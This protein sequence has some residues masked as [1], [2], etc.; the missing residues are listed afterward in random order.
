MGLA[1]THRIFHLIV[2]WSN[3]GKSVTQDY[4]VRISTSS[5]PLQCNNLNDKIDYGNFNRRP[6]GS[7]CEL[8]GGIA[9]IITFVLVV[10]LTVTAV[11]LYARHTGRW[12]FA[13]KDYSPF[14]TQFLLLLRAFPHN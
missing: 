9:A 2:E 1:D 14:I 10:V 13:G 11:T 3:K 7:L 12:C 8:A 4:V 5:A 6:V